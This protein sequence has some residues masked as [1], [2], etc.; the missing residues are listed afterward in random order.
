[1]ESVISNLFL[2]NWQRKILAVIAALIIWL[3]VNQSITDTKTIPNVPIRIVN[4]PPDKTIL[5]LLPNGILTKRINLTLSG[6]KD[7]V[8]EL[9]PGDVEVVLDASMA[10]QDE[11]IVQINKKNLVSLNPNIDLLHHITAISHSELVIKLSRLITAKIPIT[12]QPPIG[13]PPTGYEYLDFWPQKLTQNLSGPEEEIQKLKEKGFDLTFD[14]S[15]IRSEDLANLKN[16]GDSQEDEIRFLVPNKWKQI[17]IPFQNHNLVDINDPEAQYLRIY[18]LRKQTLPLEKE[19]PLAVFYPTQ[20]SETLNP[21][22]VTIAQG[23]YVNYRHHIPYLTIPLFVKDVSH[24]FLNIVRDNLQLTLIASPPK[25]RE[26]LEWSLEVISANE[27]EDTYVAYLASKLTSGK[28]TI[29]IPKRRELLIRKRFRDYIQR[30]TL[31]INQDQKLNLE[32]SLEDNKIIIA[33]D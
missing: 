28:T 19:L 4:L 12:I 8:D 6:S 31:Y 7:I 21:E 5:G 16:T 10:N 27:L 18:F 22:T 13:E 33:G 3:F 9:E 11:W 25:D 17:S 15:E 14:L 1:M 20:T 30:L 29:A 26:T 32:S 23:K 24:L 2:H